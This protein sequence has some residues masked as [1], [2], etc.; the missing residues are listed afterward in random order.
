M[1][2]AMS[3]APTDDA[4]FNTEAFKL[5]LQVAWAD[6]QLDP[7]EREFLVK[8]AKAWRVPPTTLETLL[9]HLDHGKPLPQPNLV[10][11]RDKPDKVL[12]AAEALVAA[13]GVI[14]DAEREMLG[15][16]RTILGVAS[17]D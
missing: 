16:L 9:E 14:E 17:P 12:R 1:L 10:W 5:L 4:E 2:R 11:L 13:D 3:A 7:R 6:D 8:L 15:E